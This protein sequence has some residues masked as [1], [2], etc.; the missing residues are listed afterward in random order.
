M[1]CKGKIKRKNK[2]GKVI[3]EQCGNKLDDNEIFCSKCGHPTSALEEG[4][5]ARKNIKSI[6]KLFW[7]EKN[8]YLSFSLVMLFCAFLPIAAVVF[9]TKGNYWLNNLLLLFT[10]PLAL[11]PL[12]SDKDFARSG[13]NPSSFTGNLKYYPKLWLFTG[14]NIL[15]FLLLKILCTGFLLNVATDPILH[16]VRLIL[17]FYWIAIVLPVPFL[18][19]RYNKNPLAAIKQAYKASSEIRWQLFFIG[20]FLFLINLAGALFLVIGLLFTIPL[21]YILL[22]RY[23]LRLEEYKLF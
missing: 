13:L 14:V 4:L 1:K 6:W 23:F 15:W 5:S 22:E 11:V 18:I 21:S 2:L 8:K 9:F 16:P 12:A 3:I 19:V 20:G 10:V 7:P 17:V